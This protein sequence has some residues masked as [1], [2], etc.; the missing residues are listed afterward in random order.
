MQVAKEVD[1]SNLYKLGD[2]VIVLFNRPNI[3]DIYK[4]G[5]FG[6]DEFVVN[7]IHYVSDSPKGFYRYL[8]KHMNSNICLWKFDEEIQSF[9]SIQRENRLKEIGI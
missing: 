6:D 7:K 8:I 9:I 5:K 2:K 1:S 4:S 3:P